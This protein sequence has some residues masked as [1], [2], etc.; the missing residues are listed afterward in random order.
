MRE[1]VQLKRYYERFFHF[2]LLLASQ[3]L[4]HFVAI[5]IARVHFDSSID[6]ELTFTLFQLTLILTGFHIIY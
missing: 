5:A 1:L 3:V 4:I 6:F 2:I